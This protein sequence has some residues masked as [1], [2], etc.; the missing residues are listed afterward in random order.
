MLAQKSIF[1]LESLQRMQ[2]F[3]QLHIWHECSRN[4]TDQ[5]VHDNPFYMVLK[6]AT[7]L[8]HVSPLATDCFRPHPGLQSSRPN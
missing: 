7:L 3:V 6:S 4:V 5:A 2:L 8:Q 1:S